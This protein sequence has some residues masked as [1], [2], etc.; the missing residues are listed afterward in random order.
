MAQSLG[1]KEQGEHMKCIV[2]ECK[3]VFNDVDFRGDVCLP[4]YQSMTTGWRKKQ[5]Q[6][7]EPFEYWNAVEGWVKIDPP[8]PQREPRW[9]EWRGLTDVEIEHA[10]MNTKD[11]VDMARVLEDI[12]KGKNT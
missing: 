12:L 11:F 7:R 3:N 8:E 9:K 4:C 10:Y 2:N 6:M 1:I 5:I